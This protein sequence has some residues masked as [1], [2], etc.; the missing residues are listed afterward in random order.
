[1]IDIAL[2]QHRLLW[3]GVSLIGTALALLNARGTRRLW[4]STVYDRGQLLAQTA[5]IWLLPGFAFVVTYF[6]KG[7][8]PN[9][10]PDP[11]AL[12]PETP[13]AGV[14]PGAP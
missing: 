9:R 14:A 4:R 2:D 7:D 1:M 8:Q 13:N 6:L 10:G 12:N 11:T 5:L 3:L